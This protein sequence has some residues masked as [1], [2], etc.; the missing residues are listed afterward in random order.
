[1]K[2]C[3]SQYSFNKKVFAPCAKTICAFHYTNNQSI[4]NKRQLQ[5][6]I[7]KINFSIS[8]NQHFRSVGFFLSFKNVLKN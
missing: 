2:V 7:E 4:E 8:K 3:K 1:M 6:I 5:P